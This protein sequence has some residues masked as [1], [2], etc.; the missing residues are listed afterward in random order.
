MKKSLLFAFIS[1]MLFTI[2]LLAQG[3]H[4]GEVKQ[5]DVDISFY[6]VSGQTIT[7]ATGIRYCNAAGRCSYENK[8]YPPEYWGT[9][10][11]FY[12]GRLTGITVKITNNGPRNIAKVLITTEV[13][14][15]RTDG[16]NGS[17][18]TQPRYI[19]VEVEKG[20]TKIIDA[21]FIAQYTP[22]MES[23]LDRFLVK[24]S[25][26]NQGGGKGNPEPGLIMVKEGVFCPPE[27]E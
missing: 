1:V 21:S 23:G 20:E 17:P 6:A 9:Y 15:L 2:P 27:P 19:E 7:D 22:N 4:K 25:H 11:L 13:Y 8:V 24:V 16:S 12:F 3:K 5:L 18:M 10:P 14:I 26:M